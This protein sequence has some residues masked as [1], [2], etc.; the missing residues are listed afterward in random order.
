[1]WIQTHI[2]FPERQREKIAEVQLWGGGGGGGVSV[3]A[4]V[5]GKLSVPWRPTNLDNSISRLQ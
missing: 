2:I 4:M 3:G 5:L 1:M